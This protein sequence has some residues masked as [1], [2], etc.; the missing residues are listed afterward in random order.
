MHG[1]EVGKFNKR[2]GDK[3]ESNAQTFHSWQS[4]TSHSIHTWHQIYVF[5]SET[6]MQSEKGSRIQQKLQKDLRE[7]IR[8][9][10]QI[11][12]FKNLKSQ[13]AGN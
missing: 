4:H 3:S 2:K 10:K 5:L 7:E 1:R 6:G 12:V 8:Q 11:E 9:F 13:S